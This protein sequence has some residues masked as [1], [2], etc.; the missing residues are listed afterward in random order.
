[1]S[2]IRNLYDLYKHRLAVMKEDEKTLIINYE[3]GTVL[4]GNTPS[5][6]NQ[7]RSFSS[8]SF[9]QMDIHYQNK[10]LVLSFN[11]KQPD[12]NLLFQIFLVVAY[13]VADNI[14][15][16]QAYKNFPY[17]LIP[18]SYTMGEYAFSFT[19]RERF[20]REPKK[21]IEKGLQLLN[22]QNSYF[23]KLLLPLLKIND[24]DLYDIR[25]F[26]EFVLL[27]RLSRDEKIKTTIL[28]K[29]N[30]RAKIELNKI[31]DSCNQSILQSGLFS[32][33]EKLALKKKFSFEKINLKGGSKDKIY[34]FIDS[35][36]DKFSEYKEC[37]DAW[38]VLR[39]EKGLAHGALF[40]EGVSLNQKDMAMMQ[41]LHEFLCKLLFREFIQG[42]K[43]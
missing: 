39:T 30:V 10:M 41:K 1:M 37:V 38:H 9:G 36:G 6:I 12:S 23:S 21:I 26:A 42:V 18:K 25:F 14:T 11:L 43:K 13:L 29:E 32:E 33:T 28:Q 35:L 27:E 8:S 31:L 2:R 24:L 22:N 20:I 34:L 3:L 17:G 5:E 19:N 7:P 15:L 40:S 16:F 4:L